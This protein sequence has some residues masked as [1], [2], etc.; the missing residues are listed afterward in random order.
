[1][2]LKKV[3]LIVLV[4]VLFNSAKINF[5]NAQEK[6]EIMHGMCGEKVEWTL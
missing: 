2:K 3:L 5:I 6:N 4:V 1:M